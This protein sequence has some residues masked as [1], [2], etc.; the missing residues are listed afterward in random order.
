MIDQFHRKW[1]LEARALC[2]LF[3]QTVRAEV[4]KK[5]EKDPFTEI[6]Y[7][8]IVLSRRRIRPRRQGRTDDRTAYAGTHPFVQIVI[9][10][11]HQTILE[12]TAR[13]DL[14][15]VIPVG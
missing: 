5:A 14:G 2:R 12:E 3:P 9:D 10:E 6:N 8:V 1:K 4:A 11:D 15:Y 13:P 7:R